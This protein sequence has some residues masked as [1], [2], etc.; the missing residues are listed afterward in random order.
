MDDELEE[1]L[2]AVAGRSQGGSKKRSRKAKDSEDEDYGWLTS[3]RLTKQIASPLARI[4]Q[5]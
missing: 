3:A 4:F 1:E 2:L 5:E